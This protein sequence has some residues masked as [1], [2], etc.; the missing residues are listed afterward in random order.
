MTNVGH[1]SR[2]ADRLYVALV[3][4]ALLVLLGGTLTQVSG[5]RGGGGGGGGRPRSVDLERLERLVRGGRLSDREAE[6]WRPV[7]P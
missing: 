4:L 6:F 3:V 2:A 7:G 1:A 5:G